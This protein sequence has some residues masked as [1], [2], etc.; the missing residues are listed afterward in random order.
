MG[1]LCYSSI[2]GHDEDW[3]HVT[4]QS[5]VEDG[6]CVGCS[7][8]ENIQCDLNSRWGNQDLRR[9]A[10]DW[11]ARQVWVF[12]TLSL[13]LVP[14]APPP[15]PAVAERGG[16]AAAGA[17]PKSQ[18]TRPQK[19]GDEPVGGE[20][21]PEQ[22]YSYTRT[23]AEGEDEIEEQR[24]PSRRPPAAVPPVPSPRVEV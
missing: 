18:P 11:L 17:T 21:D 19:G 23:E 12:R 2:G 5:S 13:R 24:T 7:A 16:S 15:P 9:A 8:L 4:L 1:S 6:W 20:P 14:V 3:S 22:S 10:N